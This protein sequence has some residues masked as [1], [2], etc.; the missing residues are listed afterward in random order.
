M[1]KE[2]EKTTPTQ[3]EYIT[4]QIK[5]KRLKALD[6]SRNRTSISIPMIP[7][8]ESEEHWKLYKQL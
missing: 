6:K 4:Q 8:Q 5:A 1:S 3:D 7:N 2:K